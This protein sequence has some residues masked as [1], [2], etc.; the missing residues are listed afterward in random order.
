[1]MLS[2]DFEVNPLQ[3]DVNH[4][5]SPEQPQSPSKR[6]FGPV[7][8]LF[9]SLRCVMGLKAQASR[10]CCVTRCDGTKGPGQ[11]SLLRDPGTVYIWQ[12]TLRTHDDC[13][14]ICLFL[15]IVIAF[16]Y[17]RLDPRAQTPFL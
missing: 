2:K 7:T 3:L 6:L 15:A 14:D 17:I 9:C 5:L 1:M 13:F 11:P 4:S 8:Q 10:A 12:V 16:I